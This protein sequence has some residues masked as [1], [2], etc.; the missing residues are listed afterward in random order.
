VGARSVKPR[1]KL[2]ISAAVVVVAA[3]AALVGLVLSTAWVNVSSRYTVARAE[4]AGV[5]YLRPLT[6]L[7]QT[8][9]VAESAAVRG[10]RVDTGALASAAKSV[11]D[12]D[13]RHGAKLRTSGRWVQLQERVS[14]L[15]S[16]PGRSAAAYQHFGDAI[17]LA[18]DLAAAVGDTSS[19]LLDPALDSA[20]LS[21]VALDGLPAVMVG[22]A[23]AASLATLYRPTATSSGSSS[24]GSNTGSGGQSDGGGEPPGGGGQ[25]AA[26]A[27][28]RYEVAVAAAEV[29]A[30]LKKSIE[31]TRPSLDVTL[32]SQQD[33]FTAAVDALT[34][35][36]VVQQPVAAVSAQ[37]LAEA[38]NRVQTAALALAAALFDQLDGLLA[39]RQAGLALEQKLLIAG[40][41]AVLVLAVLLLWLL[42]P[43]HR[44]SGAESDTE[45]DV[46]P[47]RPQIALIEAR[48]L[49]GAEEL[50]HVGRG[51][52][53]RPQE[54]DGAE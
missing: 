23:R 2:R 54:R 15:V 18:V 45:E 30:S 27:V 41:V 3:M 4:R 32:T 47:E 7:I 29:T 21:A 1:R 16:S 33:A 11:G 49:L 42:A 25:A 8:L 37:T 14:A 36:A 44:T 5:A 6:T 9:A 48:D 52:R 26:V 39:N 46:E 34:P 19:L 28:A 24:S 13:A 12:A 20:Y 50:I 31:T 22:A 40:G 35:P 17:A 51:V 10:Q 53:P 43:A 38:N